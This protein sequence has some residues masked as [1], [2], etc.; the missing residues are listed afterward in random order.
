MSVLYIRDENGE[1]VPVKTIKGADGRGI[2]SIELI[3]GTHEAGTNDTYRVTYTDG[4]TFDFEVYN[5]ADTAGAVRYDV[6]QTLTDAEQSQARSN[7]NALAGMTVYNWTVDSSGNNVFE[8]LGYGITG[9]VSK[10]DITAPSG[11]V[12]PALVISGNASSGI[13]EFSVFDSGGGVW[14]GSANLSSKTISISKI[15]LTA[16]DVGAL[17]LTGGTLTGDLIFP[18]EYGIVFYD[19]TGDGGT[20]VIYEGQDAADPVLSFYGINGDEPVTLRNIQSPAEDHDAANKQYVDSAVSGA[21]KI[22][23]GTYTGTGTSGSDNP[24]TLT[25]GFTPKAVF[26]GLNSDNTV[27]LYASPYIWGADNF[28]V[29]ASKTAYVNT[30][31][32]D[33]NT[34]SWYSSQ[35]VGSQLNAANT[36]YSYVAIG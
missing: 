16:D 1:F 28:V 22:E 17:P 11:M 21:V 10:G 15:T 33:E 14:R 34:M 32:L 36:V 8:I 31:S 13:R 19:S 18:Y 12:F 26:L 20:L 29:T 27:G 35:T 7:I 24:C 6:A 9:V 30:V 3:S 2:T 5:G 4:K 25:F 23:T